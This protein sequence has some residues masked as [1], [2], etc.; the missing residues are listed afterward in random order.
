[1]ECTKAAL[2]LK[3]F[4]A[5]A[6]DGEAGMA[7]YIDRQSQLATDAAALLRASPGFE[8]AVEPQ[9][10]IVYFRV[11]GEDQT[12]LNLRKR[13]IEKGDWYVSSAEFRGKR[14][15]RLALMSPE[16]EITHIQ[17]LITEINRLLP[18]PPPRA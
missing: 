4:F 10:N 5:L 11:E 12:Q 16:T 1:M 18:N 6:A 14:W 3:A 2:G 17:A 7:A 15:L 8:V 9:S 13:L